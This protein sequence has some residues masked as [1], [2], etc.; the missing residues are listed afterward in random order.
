MLKPRKIYLKKRKASTVLSA[1]IKMIL[2]RKKFIT[3]IHDIHENNKLSNQLE[4]L[5]NQLLREAEERQAAEE[6]SY[7][8]Y[9]N[10]F[11]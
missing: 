6:V 9:F 2:Q 3:M 1:W 7:Y 5:R 4:F 10:Y 8:N 11:N